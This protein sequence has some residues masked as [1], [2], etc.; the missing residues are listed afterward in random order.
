MVRL[1]TYLHRRGAQDTLRPTNRRPLDPRHGQGVWAGLGKSAKEPV[2]SANFFGLS[3]E[4]RGGLRALA[5]RRWL[6]CP[7]Q[8]RGRQPQLGR[9]RRS[10]L[11]ARD[12]QVKASADCPRA[13]VRARGLP[14]HRTLLCLFWHGSGKRDRF[15]AGLPGKHRPR[16]HGAV[17]GCRAVGWCL[18][19]GV[20]WVQ[21]RIGG[22]CMC[23]WRR[24]RLPLPSTRR[25]T[26]R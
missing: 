13:T 22:R 10:R 4:V 1:R 25:S 3:H 21:R 2:T 14:L 17:V 5:P 16:A 6:P 24:V 8:R 15:G 11:R 23:A 12:T 9:L 20:R 19:A 26:S 18:G 7:G